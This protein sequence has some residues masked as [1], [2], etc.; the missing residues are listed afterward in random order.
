MS[1][2]YK[3]IK[4]NPK[5]LILSFFIVVISLI[6]GLPNIILKVQ[7]KENYNPL[8]ISATSPVSRDETY[9]Y[10]PFVK[11]IL[12]GNFIIKDVYV[13]EYKDYPTPFVGETTPSLIF[14]FLSIITGSIENAFITGDFIFPPIIFLLMY[15]LV[16]IFLK[17]NLYAASVAFLTTIARDFIAVIPFPQTTL[18]YLTVA[19]NQNFLLH[20]SR[21]FHPQLTLIFFLA[22]FLSFLK[23]LSNLSSKV[24]LATS[25]IFFGILFYSYIFYWTYFLFFLV[26]LFLYYAFRKEVDV[27]KALTISGV[28]GLLIA[29]IYLYNIWQFRQLSLYSDFLTKSSLPHL[30]LPL[31]LIR[32]L[33][34]ALFFIIFTKP[35]KRPVT[36]LFIFLLSGVL[37]APV[38]RFILGQDLETFHYLRR[39]LM[40]L[41]TIGLFIIIFD[42]LKGNKN[43]VRI[44]SILTIL[45]AVFF[46]FGTQ[47]IATTK[48]KSAH[49]RNYDQ[50]SVFQWL[51]ESTP[52]D[53][54]V[55]SINTTFNSLIP[56]YTKNRVYF[57]PSDRTIMPTD[58]GV[59][60]YAIL[61]NIL[62]IDTLWQKKNL[63]HILSYLF[64]FQTYDQHNKLDLN[65]TRK[66][67][68]E[69]KIDTAAGQNPKTLIQRYRLDYV[70]VT[71]QELDLIHPTNF[72]RLLYVVN[73]YQ[74]YK[75]IT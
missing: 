29:S 30:P 48:I 33:L 18:Q 17:N 13:E 11:H 44:V 14:A 32:Y 5:R 23:L 8:T 2:I 75:I 66:T 63:D 55:A 71:P 19:E 74:I 73:G 41:A 54:V 36:T 25:G 50:E 12:E 26:I 72:S 3:F 57:P 59:E 61:A 20:F 24:F 16:R 9:A 28:I 51:N 6:Y 60:R 62:G 22:A 37:I 69:S 49:V 10:A 45:M 46:A 4:K 31:T 42:F 53:S 21:A 47:I 67:F 40:S 70:V 43:V 39:A 65:S 52:K 15:L 1:Y 7:L 64:I 34:I 58:E 68:A 38:S 27:A 56:V 35:R